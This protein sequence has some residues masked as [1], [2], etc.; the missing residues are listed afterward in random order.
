MP[1]TRY[2]PAGEYGWD[3]IPGVAERAGMHWFNREGGNGYELADMLFSIGPNC[4]A[5]FGDLATTPARVAGY[6]AV[7]V[8]PY[9][10]AVSYNDPSGDETSRAYKLDIAGRPLCIYVSWHATTTK[11]QVDSLLDVI[12]SIRAQPI[13][14]DGI[15]INFYLEEGWDIG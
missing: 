9:E 3:A 11:A 8:E 2:S 12:E 7:Y 6:G 4:I 10:P 15:R 5:E 13:I 1:A 14:S